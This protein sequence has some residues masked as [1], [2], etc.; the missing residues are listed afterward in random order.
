MLFQSTK[1]TIWFIN[2]SWQAKE[3]LT[4][5]IALV[6]ME[7]DILA[8][9]M[10]FL[11]TNVGQNPM[12]LCRLKAF[13]K[14]NTKVDEVELIDIIYLTFQKLLTIFLPRGY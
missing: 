8:S 3:I 4:E 6:I 9:S 10:Y 11:E 14:Y 12:W 1:E 2:E 5:T 7:Y 13:F